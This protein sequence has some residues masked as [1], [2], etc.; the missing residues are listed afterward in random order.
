MR[1]G[2]GQLVPWAGTIELPAHLNTE[3]QPNVANGMWVARN[4][5][6]HH[7]FLASQHVVQRGHARVPRVDESESVC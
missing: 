1:P 6:K 4:M 5:P 7:G 2:P 3:Q